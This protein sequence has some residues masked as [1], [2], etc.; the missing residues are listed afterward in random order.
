MRTPTGAIVVVVEVYDGINE[1]LVQWP[2]GQFAQFRF[3]HLHPLPGS[4]A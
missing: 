4:E 3:S 1:A 2:E